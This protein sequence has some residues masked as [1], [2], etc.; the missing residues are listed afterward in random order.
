M[1]DA[2]DSLWKSISSDVLD[3]KQMHNNAHASWKHVP[4]FNDSTYAFVVQH[5][6]RNEKWHNQNAFTSKSSSRAMPAIKYQPCLSIL[7]MVDKMRM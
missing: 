2:W 7:D 4:H 1:K 6:M 5:H 3:M